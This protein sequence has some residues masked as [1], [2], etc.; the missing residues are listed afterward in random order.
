M[1]P[2][3]FAIRLLI[4]FACML[5][6]TGCTLTAPTLLSEARP[7]KPLFL[8]EPTSSPMNARLIV[9]RDTGISGEL[10][11]I[12]VFLDGRLI[13]VLQAGDMVEFEVRPDSYVL[14]VGCSPCNDEFRRELQVIA[15][16]KKSH[17]FRT[18]FLDGL[19]I[20]PSSQVK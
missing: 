1:Q 11:A 3:W 16:A 15:K 12:T 5:P 4:T 20:Q 13:G 17:Y 2:R 19:E 9:V 7:V 10:L 18:M 8:P 6:L 14:G